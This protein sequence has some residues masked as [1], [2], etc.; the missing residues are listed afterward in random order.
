[1]NILCGL[2][3]I[4]GVK[5]IK[6]PFLEDDDSIK[7]LN[8]NIYSSLLKLVISQRNNL[9]LGVPSHMISLIMTHFPLTDDLLEAKDV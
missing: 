7:L 9:Q 6:H 8:D 4:D 1:M 3:N 2:A 5:Q